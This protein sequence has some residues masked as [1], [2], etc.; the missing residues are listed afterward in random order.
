[1]PP[2]SY[3]LPASLRLA[4]GLVLGSASLVWFKSDAAR[5][6]LLGF[7][8]GSPHD[9]A[10]ADVA[11]GKG[12][13]L[14]AKAAIGTPKGGKALKVTFDPLSVDRKRQ[15]AKDYLTKPVHEDVLLKT[16]DRQ[17]ADQ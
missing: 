13:G 11:P 10:G 17:L 16:V 14:G 5:L 1:M 7:P 2:F 6:G 8:D 12:K 4:S 3:Y 15:G 9:G